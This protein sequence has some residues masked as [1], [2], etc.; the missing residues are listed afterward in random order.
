MSDPPANMMRAPAAGDDPPPQVWVLLDDRP[1]NTTQ[2]TGLAEA[3]G[4]PHVVKQLVMRPFAALNNRVL[5][6]SLLGIDRDRSDAL[7][8]P[9]PDLV[10]AAGRRTAPVAQWIRKQNGGR[11]KLV[12]LGRKAGDAAEL[13]DLAVTPEFCRCIPHPNR[14]ETG[15]PLHRM[16][17]AT[18]AAAAEAWSDRLVQGSPTPRVALLVG[19]SSGQYR[20]D[21][22]T[23]RSVGASVAEMMAKSGGSLWVSTSRRSGES[24]ADALANA[25]GP[26]AH[27]H[28][29]SAQGGEN[30]YRGYLACADAF[31]ITADSESMLVEACSTGRPV[32]IYPLPIRRSFRVLNFFRDWVTWHS[33]VGDRTRDPGAPLSAWTRFCSWLIGRG[34]V[35]HR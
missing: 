32:Y 16:T 19:G 11:T 5:G 21:V 25:L 26:V 34:F 14:L 24:Q 20:F 27:F 18:L 12:A 29:W 22:K 31:V 4:W 13:V 28:R 33:V 35:H 30:P 17:P 6:A 3:L 2:S 23:A 8:E 1:G 9:W 10:I 15:G 7:Q